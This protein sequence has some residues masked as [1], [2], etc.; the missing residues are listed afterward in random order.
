M[1]KNPRLGPGLVLMRCVVRCVP[2]LALRPCAHLCALLQS[3]QALHPWASPVLQYIPVQDDLHCT[4]V[5]VNRYCLPEK[6]QCRLLPLETRIQCYCSSCADGDLKQ[7]VRTHVQSC[8]GA[9][10]NASGVNAAAPY[11][12][13]VFLTRRRHAT[14]RIPGQQR[15]RDDYRFAC[16]ARGKWG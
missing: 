7:A 4:A 6:T 9:T 10:T 14:R 12:Q 8:R 3:R 16:A 13:C 5:Q 1:S 2:F 11:P 15:R